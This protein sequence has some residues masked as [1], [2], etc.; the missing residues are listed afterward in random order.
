MRW[1]TSNSHVECM[2]MSLHSQ[3]DLSLNSSLLL[4]K[5]LHTAAMFKKFDFNLLLNNEDATAHFLSEK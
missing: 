5:I 4:S 3:S 2:N 1:F